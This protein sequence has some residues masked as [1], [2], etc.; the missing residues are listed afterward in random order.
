MICGWEG[1]DLRHC[2]YAPYNY[3]HPGPEPAPRPVR[4]VRHHGPAFT[5]AAHQRGGA[6]GGAGA[7][8]G[9][10]H[11]RRH[12]GHRLCHLCPAE[13]RSIEEAVAKRRWTGCGP[14]LVVMLAPGSTRRAAPRPRRA[15]VCAWKQRCDFASESGAI[16][17]G[18]P[19]P[20]D[21]APFSA[22]LDFAR[23][24]CQHRPRLRSEDR[25]VRV[26]VCVLRPAGFRRR[27]ASSVHRAAAVRA[28]SRPEHPVQADAGHGAPDWLYAA[29]GLRPEQR[30]PL[31]HRLFEEQIHRAHL[32]PA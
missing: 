6:A 10:P 17:C 21:I 3:L 12:R 24:G 8:G 18:G 11:H 28:P 19:C 15:S 5:G 26:R 22:S 13:R 1:P 9:S 14:S 20:R 23:A 31:R 16:H 27:T 2:R 4:H 29:L 32:H 30:H 25:P 7:E